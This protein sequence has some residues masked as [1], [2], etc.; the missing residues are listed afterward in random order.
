MANVQP[1]LSRF[2]QWKPWPPG[3]PAPEIWSIIYELDRR[4]QV[5]VVEA[6]LNAQIGMARAHIEGLE[7]IR[8]AISGASA[9]KTG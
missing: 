9:A 8:K 1:E 7:S 3:D 5:Q 4:V 2:L 6:V